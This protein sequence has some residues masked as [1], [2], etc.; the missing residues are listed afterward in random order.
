[1]RRMTVSG[2][3]NNFAVLFSARHISNQLPSTTT[4][5][6]RNVVSFAVK[7]TEWVLLA[8][9]IL[10][11]F[12]G[13]FNGSEFLFLDVPDEVADLVTLLKKKDA[14]S[15]RSVRFHFRS[16]LDNDQQTSDHIVI[17]ASGFA[18]KCAE[19]ERG[20]APAQ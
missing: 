14:G 15:D 2:S 12:D 9:A 19:F 7:E 17:D 1:M 4:W 18:A 6:R 20:C 10:I 5:H 3:W 13:T 16:G 11:P 8:G